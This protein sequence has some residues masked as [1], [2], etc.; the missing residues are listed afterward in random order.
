MGISQSGKGG[1]G[2][3]VPRLPREEWDF[4]SGPDLKKNTKKG[5]WTGGIQFNFLP[6]N[7]VTFCWLYEFSRYDTQEAELY[8]KW[9]A[10]AER[11]DDFDS[12]LDHYRRTDPDGKGGYPLVADWFYRIWPEW[13]EKP[14]L[15]V[16]LK[17]RQRR[18]KK[19]WANEPNRKLRLIP[20]REIY[21][22]VVERNAGN[23]PERPRLGRERWPLEMGEDVWTIRHPRR[24]DLLPTEIVA[25]EIDLKLSNETLCARLQS[26]LTQR[27]KKKGYKLPFH[28]ETIA[29][30][31]DLIALGATRLMDSG[32]SIR[33]AMDCSER[34]TGKALYNDGGDW[35]RA[36]NRAG[37]AMQGAF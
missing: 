37:K 14:Y 22:Y 8:S 2:A 23:N 29:D 21:R 36:R 34:I 30:R 25:F 9:R 6:E 7:E 12:L 33:E 3:N 13:P 31:S 15:S 18:F 5:D 19:T 32:L 26:W 10:G 35:S 20:L 28:R 16:P 17:E 24:N 1:T 4:R 11:P 27:R